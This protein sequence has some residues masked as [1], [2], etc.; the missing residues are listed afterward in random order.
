MSEIKNAI[1]LAAGFGRRLRPLTNENPKCLTKINGKPIIENTLEILIKN[2]IQRTVIVVG[3]LGDIIKDW[4]GPEYQG[5]PISYIRN[6]IFHRSNSMYSLFL[7]RKYLKEGTILIEGDTFF[8][9][10]LISG[11]LKQ[12][13]NKVEESKTTEILYHDLNVRLLKYGNVYMLVV[14][15]KQE[16]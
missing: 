12:K 8:E 3:Y 11:V 5:M 15:W 7:A 14:R 10:A 2:G 4:I 9:E 6:E 13:Q 1:I 16:K